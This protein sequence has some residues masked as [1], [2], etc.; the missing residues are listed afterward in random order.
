[1][2]NL[3]NQMAELQKS[4]RQELQRIA[5]TY[6][7][8]LEI[9]MQH[10]NSVQT[11]LDQAIAQS[12]VTDQAQVALRELESNA[13]TYQALY[14]NFLQRYMESVQQQSF[15][16]TETRVITAASPPLSPD[17]PRTRLILALGGGVGLGVRFCGRRLA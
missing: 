6:K 4:I 14:D 10:E 7:S 1:M 5:E 15:P 16:V 3:R 2:V 8:D 11:Q 17:H 13:Q 9:A 12:Q